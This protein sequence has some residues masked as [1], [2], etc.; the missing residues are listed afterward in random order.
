MEGREGYAEM[1]RFQPR[2]VKRFFE[3]LDAFLKIRLFTEEEIGQLLR[4][5]ALSD[6]RSYIDLVLNA[7]VVGYNDE[8]LPELSR[9]EDLFDKTGKLYELC[10]SVNPSMEIGRISIAAEHE[11]RAELHLLPGRAPEPA[12]GFERLR[13]IES[14]LKERIVGQDEAIRAV[15]RAIRKAVVGFRDPERPVATFFFMGQTGVGKTELAKALAVA[16]YG[17]ASPMVRVD[18][19]EYALPHEYAKLLGSPPGYVGYDEGGRLAEQIRKAGSS[20]FVALFDEIEK[21]D[22]KLH[23]LLLQVMDEG[24]VTDAKGRGLDFKDAVVILTSNVGSEELDRLRDR[25]GFHGAA[26]AADPAAVRSELLP[27]VRRRFPPEFINRLTE[28]VLFNPIGLPECERIIVVLLD[29]VRRRALSIPIQ[30]R[31]DPPVARFL[32]ERGFRPEWGARELRRTVEK[33][34]ESPLSEMVLEKEL[35]RGDGVLVQVRRDRLVFRRN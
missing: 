25:I 6:R 3:P 16:L 5:A 2:I 21:S 33:E 12:Q 30:V 13:S 17:A 8:V 1:I 20:S 26:A 24:R 29:Q 27:A 19:S 11:A 15:T 10:V 35:D 22:P 32:A 4:D 31:F 14:S 23:H 34:I 18:C 7:C 9:K 28:I